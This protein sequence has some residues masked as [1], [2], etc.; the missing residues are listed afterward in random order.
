M[1]ASGFISA[2][3]NSSQRLLANKEKPMN[4]GP[5]KASKHVLD[6][7]ISFLTIGT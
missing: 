5:E 1:I 4:A 6:F 7:P 3:T 2:T